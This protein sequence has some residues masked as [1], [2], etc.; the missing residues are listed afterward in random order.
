MT[1]LGPASTCLSDGGRHGGGGGGAHGRSARPNAPFGLCS[2]APGPQLARPAATT[3]YGAP[4]AN[5]S[6]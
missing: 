3:V 4:V 6:Q 1:S 5:Y 2:D